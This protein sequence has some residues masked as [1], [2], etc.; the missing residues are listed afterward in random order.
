[1]ATT[2]ELCSY[3][4]R[5]EGS[6]VSLGDYYS[7]GATGTFATLEL[8]KTA[9]AALKEP[10]KGK[11]RHSW[12]PNSIEGVKHNNRYCIRVQPNAFGLLLEQE[13]NINSAK[14]SGIKK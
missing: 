6:W 11:P 3:T 7:Q 9:A 14:G 10:P 12:G 8:A 5:K 4:W 1:M 2:Y 13:L